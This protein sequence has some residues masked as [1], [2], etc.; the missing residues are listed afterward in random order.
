[1]ANDGVINIDIIN[2]FVM[3]LLIHS[4][5]LTQLD[6][7]D[8]RKCVQFA[9]YGSLYV[10]PTLYGWVKF[11]S[12]LWPV[13]N[14]QSAIKKTILEQLSYGPTV[15]ATFFFIISLLDHKTVEE[16]KQ[17]VRDKFWP[18]YKVIVSNSHSTQSFAQIN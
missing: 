9:L 1:M 12:R 4:I 8:W 3:S 15:T 7:Y 11:T 17:E 5:H 6:T 10:A 18:T 2:H 14:V 13:M 16:S